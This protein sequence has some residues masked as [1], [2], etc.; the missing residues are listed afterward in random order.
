LDDERYG[1]GNAKSDVVLII[2]Y[3]SSLSNTDKEYCIEQIKKM[4]EQVPGKSLIVSSKNWTKIIIYQFFNLA[5]F[6][7]FHDNVNLTA[8]M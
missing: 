6:I 8:W 7:L 1:L 4:K 2:P 5:Y 3:E